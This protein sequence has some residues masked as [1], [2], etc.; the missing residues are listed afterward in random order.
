MESKDLINEIKKDYPELSEKL[1][2]LDEAY[3]LTLR[4]FNH[5]FGNAMTLVSSSLQI[6]ES[7]HPEVKDFKYWDTTRADVKHMVNMISDISSFNNCQPKKKENIDLKDLLLSIVS[8]FSITQHFSHIE[9]SFKCNCTNPTILGDEMK[10][11]QVFINLIKNSSEAIATDKE[12]LLKITIDSENDFINI[13]ISD[14]GCG[15]DNEQMEK[16]FIPLISFKE[17]G[18]GLGLPIS[19]R[20]IDAHN[21]TL[22]ISSTP[23]VGTV[24]TITLKKQKS[25]QEL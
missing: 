9:Y 8:S 10:L 12:G 23:N 20:I 21:G 25:D 22:K 17:N 11:R 16:I 19:K 15:I 4:R 2:K 24:T 3:N 1:D 5:E 13:S 18:T 14:N 6:I 7:S